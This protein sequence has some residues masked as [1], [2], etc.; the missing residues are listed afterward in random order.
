MWTDGKIARFFNCLENTT[1][2]LPKDFDPNSLRTCVNRNLY[3]IL[4]RNPNLLS[5]VKLKDA[6]NQCGF[7]NLSGKY[8]DD[9]SINA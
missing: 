1:R 4:E 7:L 8:N 5:K 6:L 3:R 2:H 9:L